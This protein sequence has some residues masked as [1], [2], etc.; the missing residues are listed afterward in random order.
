MPA[1]FNLADRAR[2]ALI[3][4]GFAPDFPPQVEKELQELPE[5]PDGLRD[6][7][8]LLWSSI[9]NED[10]RDLDQIEY[11]EQADNGCI[12]LFIGI[13]DVA[14]HVRQG[15]A[16]DDR[17]HQNTVSIYTAG[18]TFHLLPEELSAGRT[19]LLEGSDHA[20]VVAEM[21]VQ[22]DGEID[23]AGVYRA[24]VRNRARL[25]YEQ[26]AAHF[27]GGSGG[28]LPQGEAGLPEQLQLQSVV[29]Q[30]LIHLRKKMG[31][32]TFSSYEARPVMRDGVVVDLELVRHNKARDLIECFMVA[33][34]V[35]TATF[36]K[37]R[38]WP[39]IERVVRAPRRWDRIRQIASDLGTELPGEP[40][41]KPLADFL[42]ARRAADPR[43]FQELSLSIVKL[44]GAGE[45]VVEY[46]DGPQTAHFG[47]AVDDYS[48]STAPNRRFSDLV[49]QRLLLASLA[50][51]SIP[52]SKADLQEIAVRCTARERA[53]R[54][55]ERFMRKVAAAFIVRNRIGQTFEAVV[56]GAS[57][58]GVFVR[59]RQ[60][61]I[62]GKVIRGE[63]GMDVGERVKVKLLSVDPEMAHIDFARV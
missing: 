29:A 60:P 49:L 2:R 19:S 14:S 54:K 10:S 11:A 16:I 48:H 56:T 18:K 15:G 30:R 3:E 5:T 62:E 59:V 58:K 40:Q 34:N 24:L 25:N 47:L 13:A 12:R 37:D 57:W 35:A 41:P 51:E 21:L 53:A 45:Y 6:L 38:G 32:L 50:G 4:R 1:E 43:N 46:P 61:P 63:L 20:A 7:R 22:P 27:D 55:V 8:G 39:I 9:D 52:Y 23:Q 44:L 42:A 33:A 26:V 17:A 31:A 28:A 36:L